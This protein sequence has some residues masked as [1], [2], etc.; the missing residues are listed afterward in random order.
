MT[1]N[2][3][4][5]NYANLDKDDKYAV[6][7]QLLLFECIETQITEYTYSKD[8]AENLLEQISYE[9]G[10]HA[11]QEAQQNVYNEILDFI[12]FAIESYDRPVSEIDTDD[13]FYGLEEEL[14]MDE[15]E[16]E[17]ARN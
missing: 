10:L 4:I 15:E 13:P 6:Q 7:A 1:Y 5:Y 12:Q 17:N 14:N 11:L 16:L 3:R 2:T 9:E 8:D